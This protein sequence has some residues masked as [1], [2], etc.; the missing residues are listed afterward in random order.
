MTRAVS[1]S[2]PPVLSPKAGIQSKAERSSAPQANFAEALGIGKRSGQAQSS[3]MKTDSGEA[4]PAPAW[5]HL[6]S[7]I[8]GLHP[9]QSEVGIAAAGS[10]PEPDGAPE[11]DDFTAKQPDMPEDLAGEKHT[12]H[13]GLRD[14]MANLAAPVLQALRERFV[15]TDRVDTS[16]DADGAGVSSD[17]NV[18]PSPQLFAGDNAES[19]EAAPPAPPAART[20]DTPKSRLTLAIRAG[21]AAAPLQLDQ[22]PALGHGPGILRNMPS[23]GDSTPEIIPERTPEPSKPAPR[24]TVVAQQNIPAPMQSTAVALVQSIASGD[25]LAPPAAATTLNAIHA[26]ATHASAQSLKI[27]L[28][29]AEL[30]MVTATLR[31]AG[32]RLSI[33]LRVENQD[34]YRRLTSD[35]D[36]IIGSLRDLGYEID[37]VSVIQPSLANASASRT[38]ALTAPT[39]MSG[40]SGDQ[41]GSATSNGGSAGSG[42]RPS[43]NG[44]KQGQSSQHSAPSRLET[45]DDDLYI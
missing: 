36:T 11:E 42:E 35:S 22:T 45:A 23:A 1:Q 17:I 33:E 43:G 24:A 18:A 20:I 14:A 32:E 19:G 31:F 5:P 26:S 28:H 39:L 15:Q 25:L 6:A 41:F 9:R 21:E 4:S 8:G 27:Q 37:K 2:L 34:A 40:R 38:E 29:P 44:G 13:V 10:E 3:N 16:R 30:G 12:Q 7:R